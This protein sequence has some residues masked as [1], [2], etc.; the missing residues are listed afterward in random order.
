MLTFHLKC[1]VE[2]ISL[3]IKI[4]KSKIL[5]GKPEWKRPI[6]TGDYDVRTSLEEM[7]SRCVK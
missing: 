2:D 1:F 6:F 4:I 5:V 7:S 3:A